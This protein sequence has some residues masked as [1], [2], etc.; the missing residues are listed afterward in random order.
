MKLTSWC[1]LSRIRDGSSRGSRIAASI[2]F[3]WDYLQNN[4]IPRESSADLNTIQSI[5]TRMLPTCRFNRTIA[6]DQDSDAPLHFCRPMAVKPMQFLTTSIVLPPCTMMY[7]SD[8]TF[9]KS[10]EHCGHR[11]GVLPSNTRRAILFLRSWLSFSLSLSSHSQLPDLRNSLHLPSVSKYALSKLSRPFNTSL[12]PQPLTSLIASTATRSQPLARLRSS[13]YT[14]HHC[15]A[16]F[17]TRPRPPVQ[18]S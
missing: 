2:L 8:E 10:T 1:I 3:E 4:I 6:H 18:S 11:R 12:Y 5:N 17:S 9:L 14:E 13:Y 7:S 15:G 16:L